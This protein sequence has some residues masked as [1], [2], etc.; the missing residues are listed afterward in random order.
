LDQLTTLDAMDCMSLFIDSLALALIS[1]KSPF[2][3]KADWKLNRDTKKTF[4][5]K[6]KFFKKRINN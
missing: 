6:I 1:A 3:G 4:K 2:Q 5:S